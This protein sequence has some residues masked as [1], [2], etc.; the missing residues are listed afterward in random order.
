MFLIESPNLPTATRQQYA[1]ASFS[2]IGVATNAGA[3]FSTIDFTAGQPLAVSGQVPVV[4]VDG[5]GTVIL[6][7]G[8]I[9]TA[10]ATANNPSYRPAVDSGN[11]QQGEFVQNGDTVTVYLREDEAPPSLTYFGVLDHYP[12]EYLP[13]DEVPGPYPEIYSQWNLEGECSYSRSFEGHPTANFKFTTSLANYDQVLLAFANRTPIT[14]YDMGF[15]VDSCEITERSRDLFP[16]GVID[17]SVSLTGRHEYLMSEPF[18]M[19]KLGSKGFSTTDV[20]TLA[21]QVGLNVQGARMGVTIAPDVSYAA[22]ATVANL[23]DEYGRLS[24]GFTYLSNPNAIELRT[25]GA[26]QQHTIS[27]ADI[28]GEFSTSY[29]GKEQRYH[30]VQLAEV[31]KKSVLTFNEPASESAGISVTVNPKESPVD[32]YPVAD[33]RSI[34]LAFDNGGPT[35]DQTITK[36]IGRTTI[37]TRF[38]KYGYAFAG[39]DVYSV[40]NV[41]VVDPVTNS[42]STVKQTLYTSGIVP[43][44][45]WKLVEETTTV[46]DRDSSGYLQKISE[47]GTRLTR[48]KSEGAEKPET[49]DLM[50]ARASVPG[51]GGAADAKRLVFT[52]Q[53]AAYQFNLIAPTTKIT[54]YELGNL[55][56]YFVD[57]PV[58]PNEPPAKFCLRQRTYENT[59]YT[60]PDPDSTA[61]KPLPLITTGRIF[62]QNIS[63]SITSNQKGQEAYDRTTITQNSE[64]TNLKNGL[65]IGNT[66]KVNGRPPTHDLS[67]DAIVLNSS[68]NPQKAVVDPNFKY[69]LE[70]EGLTPGSPPLYTSRIERGSKSYTTRFTEDAR[71]AAELDLAITNSE[72]SA[73]VSPDIRYNRAYREG[74]LCWIRGKQY[75]IFGNSWSEKI[76]NGRVTCDGMKLDL[77]RYLRIPVLLRKV[78]AN[79]PQGF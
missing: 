50:L 72:R 73:S 34:G 9:V 38:V 8:T 44:A 3:P 60:A 28:L 26:T 30:G 56:S 35:K 49:L 17:V 40:V 74:D 33:L 4:V 78:L 65:G 10:L 32:P 21:Q 77:G 68:I 5:V 52:K 2:S 20:A 54:E 57:T 62:E 53:I 39:V 58:S 37:E 42:S 27:D 69:L 18:Y 1:G 29:P 41:N 16:T 45:F 12:P 11:P 31:Y 15:E 14:L 19:R 36:S 25:F 43:A 48:L 46:W 6:P 75:I 63:V 51:T 47:T 64:G 55:N 71:A 23:M 67:S 76:D 22:T 70:V 79:L 59:L 24:Q 61:K 7:E 66:E 13:T